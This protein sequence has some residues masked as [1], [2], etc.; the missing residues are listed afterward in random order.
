MN[1]LIRASTVLACSELPPQEAR[2]VS[3]QIKAQPGAS[4]FIPLLSAG[5]RADFISTFNN[6]FG[7][8]ALAGGFCGN[9]EP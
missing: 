6:P 8:F 3:A 5:L 7:F 1:S 2:E 9:K 4:F